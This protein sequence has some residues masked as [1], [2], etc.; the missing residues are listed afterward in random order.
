LKIEDIESRLDEHDFTSKQ[1]YQFVRSLIRDKKKGK[2]EYQRIT[3]DDIERINLAG[4][5]LSKYEYAIAKENNVNVNMSDYNRFGDVYSKVKMTIK[6]LQSEYII[7]RVSEALGGTFFFHIAERDQYEDY[8]YNLIRS[9][10]GKIQEPKI[11]NTNGF[12]KDIPIREVKNDL[13]RFRLFVEKDGYLAFWDNSGVGKRV[14][15]HPEE[16][17]RGEF[18]GFFAGQDVL[19]G[20]AQY[21]EVPIG[22]G[23]ADVVRIER[24]GIKQFF[25]LKVITE[26]NNRFTGGL[27]QLFDYMCKED[28]AV[29]Y[30]LVFEARSP[31]NRNDEFKPEYIKDNKKILVTVIDIHPIAPTKKS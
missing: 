9:I 7:D 17:A 27:N 16:I 1:V 12:R 25:E 2:K 10:I 8:L 20:G 14:K 23:Y 22:A 21:R 5:F 6:G 11:P 29:G 24:S 3:D 26:E 15:N 28:V 18:M 19:I 13:H 30:Y 31:N 4:L